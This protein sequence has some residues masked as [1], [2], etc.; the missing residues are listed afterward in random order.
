MIIKNPYNFIAKHYRLITLL[1]LVPM[2][3]LMLKYRDIAQFFREFIKNGYNTIETNF[4]DTYVTTLTFG[5]LALMVLYNAAMYITLVS[6]KKGGLFY[7][8]GAITYIVEIVLALLFHG[9]MS[10]I[11]DLDATFVNFVRDMANISVLPQYALIVTTL[12]IGLG[13]N[14]KTLRF[15]KK[16]VLSI[17]EDE[18]E[19]EIKIGSDG[20]S[21]KR[22][23]V[24]LIREL[25]YYVL[26]NK[27]VFSVIGVVVG[28]GLLISLFIN[29]RVNNRV[30][31]F[32]QEVSTNTFNIALKD[33]YITNVDYRGNVI[34]KDTYFLAIK[35][36]L[37][38]NSL[39]DT[40]I[41]KSV[42]RITNGKNTYFP[43]YDRSSR[44]IDIGKPYEGQ[45]IR[46]KE[47]GDYVFVYQLNK[48]QVKSS[49]KLKILNTLKQEN[50]ELKSSYK[51]INVKPRNITKEINLGDV[52]VGKA[53]KLSDTTLGD[54][55]FNIKSFSIEET[56]SYVEKKCDEYTCTELK[57]NI[58]P[59]IGHVL[60]IIEDE[61]KYDEKSSYYKNS[62]KDFYGDFISLIIEP[63][64]IAD[65]E[66]NTFI[67]P[68]KNVTPKNVTGVKVYEVSMD[69][70]NAK[71]ID[72][73]LKIRNNKATLHLVG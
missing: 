64:K 38:N 69:A 25:K 24:H 56:Y 66:R 68:M 61:I 42:F 17:N 5:A 59:S 27:L 4:A 37:E 48:N 67:S 44:F 16:S 31:T 1:T 47:S 63:A 35:I 71:K 40:T 12:V 26:E 72:M 36:G 49:Y 60:M 55:T 2:V 14:I 51:T 43:T 33:S 8:I 3:Y 28:I 11:K 65:Q 22:N 7:A 34:A 15:E 41:D 73:L 57:Q 52:K 50:G 20:N 46:Y 6:K 53:I 9:S 70:L 23:A 21:A 45:I 58:V 39:E 13:F 62:D 10:G 54:T 30:Y 32:N 29:F 19:I 18:E